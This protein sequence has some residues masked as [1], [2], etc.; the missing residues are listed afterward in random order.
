MTA[1]T[2]KRHNLPALLKHTPE[3][4]IPDAVDGLKTEASL[5]ISFAG[6]HVNDGRWPAAR[7]Q[8]ANALRLIAWIESLQSEGGAQ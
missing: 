8:L 7:R 4:R 6:S 1:T 3:D 5:C 2:P